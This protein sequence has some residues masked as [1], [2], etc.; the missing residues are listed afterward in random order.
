MNMLLRLN[1]G[2]LKA[3]RRSNGGALVEFALILPMMMILIVGMFS[4]GIA[5]NNYMVLTSIV[6]SSARYLALSHSISAAASD[7]CKYAVQQA[8]ANSPSL[9]MS[10]VTWTVN[11][12]TFDTSGNGT[13]TTYTGS[14]GAAPSCSSQAATTGDNV[15]VSAAYPIIFYQYG[16]VPRSL[17]LTARSSELMQ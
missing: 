12:T 4:I 15:A 5:L 1:F 2:L 13:T 17:T 6:G 11:W 16:V 10:N 3:L 8:T 7:P 14:A 9:N